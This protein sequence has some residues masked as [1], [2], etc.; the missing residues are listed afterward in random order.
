MSPHD[1]IHFGAAYYH[2]YYRPGE[3]PSQEGL[4]R[5]LDLMAAAGFS[6]IRV[7]ESVWSTWEPEDG[8]FEL[9]WLQPVLDGAHARGIDVILGTPTYA[10]PMWLARRYPEVNA[11][12]ATGRPLG[13]G[14]RQ[15]IDYTHPVFR[16]YAERVLRKIVGRYADHPAVVGYQVDNEPGLYLFHNRGVF[17]RF[18]DELRQ[19]YGTVE[20]LNEAWGLVYWSHRLST[21]ADLWTPDNNAQPQYDLAWRRFQARLTTEMIGWQADAVRELARADQWVTT[22]IAYSR[23]AIDDVELGAVLDVTAGNPYYGMQDALAHPGGATPAQGWMTQGTAAIF[24]IADRMYSSRGAEYLVTET[25]AASIGGSSTSFPA[26]PGQW[27]QSAWAFV[28]RGARQV[29]YWHWHTLHYGTETYW[30]GVLPHSGRPGRPYREIAALGNELAR[31]GAQVAGSLPDH[32]VALLYTVDDDFALA[33]QPPL[34]TPSAQPD[35]TSYQRMVAAFYQGAFDAGA[36]V[37]LVR[38]DLFAQDPA[39]A[40]AEH[41]V[42]V[43]VAHYVASDDDLAWLRAYAAAGG[44]LVVGPRTGYADTEARA[45]TDVQP[46]GL[47]QAA[48]ASYDELSNL[49]V[50]VRVV[51]GDEPAL[52]LSGGAEAV[53]W[54]EYLVPDEGTAVLARYD[55]PHLSAWAAVTTREH[56]SGRVTVVGTVPGRELG[57]RLFSWLVPAPVSGWRDLPESVTVHTQTHPDGRRVHVVHN[58]SWDAVDITVPAAL[59]VLAA[60]RGEQPADPP[61]SSDPDGAQLSAGQTVRL[62]SW[63]VLVAAA[64]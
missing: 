37:R 6:V 36:Q 40:A 56:G 2:E 62:G 11:E 4:D 33:G 31:V 43:V 61:P 24:Q 32:D 17:Q 59:T 18:V 52:G 19:Q 3:H 45:R 22:C 35:P 8:R 7:G 29:E 21:W 10:V 12:T 39:A 5:D 63:D 14:A 54:A 42:L 50:P 20:A 60:A 34:Q 27:R 53:A 1:R 44:H 55:H 41:P 25:N 16:Y 58:W 9:D 49:S 47:A 30:G 15:E 28:A 23:P 13:W 51:D 48:G 64:R 26:Y 46:G 38:A 57:K